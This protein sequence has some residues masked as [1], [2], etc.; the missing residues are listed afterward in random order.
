MLFRSTFKPLFKKYIKNVG[1]LRI[2]GKDASV[3]SL[4]SHS[5]MLPYIM[6]IISELLGASELS[7]QDKKK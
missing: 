3:D 1:G 4:F 5:S 7:E 6:E 2:N